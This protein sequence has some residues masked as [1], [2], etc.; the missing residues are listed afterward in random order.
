MITL[1]D[2][3]ECYAAPDDD[4]QAAFISF[5]QG[6]KDQILVADYSFNLPQFTTI[7]PTLKANGVDIKFV[8]D[9]SQSFGKTEKPIVQQLKDDGFDVVIGTSD[10]HQIMHDKFVIVDDKVL[11][12]SWNFT[13]NASKEDNFFIVDPDITI[14][15]WFTGI[16]TKINNWIVANEPQS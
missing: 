15:H 8:L 4:T 11:Y 6:A 10:K 1:A 12:G 7:M 9:R 14:T 16:W 13:T 5:I 3:R 2:G